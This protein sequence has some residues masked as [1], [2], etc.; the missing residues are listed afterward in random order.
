QRQRWKKTACSCLRLLADGF[1]VLGFDFREVGLDR[2]EVLLVFGALA[3]I[4]LRHFFKFGAKQLQV[5]GSVF[6]PCLVL[7]V[8]EGLAAC[9]Q[10]GLGR[11][12]LCLQA[13]VSLTQFFHVLC[14]IIVRFHRYRPPP[15]KYGSPLLPFRRIGSG[16]APG[17]PSDPRPRKSSDFLVPPSPGQ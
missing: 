2:R 11:N 17:R 5:I 14:M 12:L 3:L 16:F 1:S 8:V 7:E 9:R 13:F 6:L 10:I 15:P 4:L